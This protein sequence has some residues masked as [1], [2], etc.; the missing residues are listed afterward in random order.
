M[1]RIEIPG[2]APL[3]LEHLICDYNGT[4][5]C[6][7]QLLAGVTERFAALS[8]Q[9]QLHVL[10][11]DTHGTVAAQIAG[12]PCQLA[13]IPPTDQQAAKQRYL[14]QLGADRCAALGN[15]R[16]DS[17]LLR[18]AALGIALLQQEGL[19][20]MALQAADLLCTSCLDAFDL[21]LQPARLQ[22]SLRC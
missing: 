21:L 17:L 9:L 3:Q 7:G 11:A 5:A 18:D 6:D 4:L 20:V 14:H 1:L 15:G 13:V 8:G 10:T 22:A 2:A 16:N 19:A 12:L